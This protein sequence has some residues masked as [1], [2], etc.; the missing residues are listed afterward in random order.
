MQKQ[1]VILSVLVVFSLTAGLAFAA[2]DMS[3]DVPFAFYVGD[4]VYPAGQYHFDMNADKYATASFVNIWAAKSENDLVIMATAGTDK[5]A[6]SNQL[7]FNKY[8]E[9]HFLSSITINGYKAT[10][11]VLGL[12]KEAISQAKQA[13]G[14]IRV[15]QK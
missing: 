7:V 1:L 8:G 5:N 15:A 2:I 12:E 4:Q 3:V 9:K 14:V 11:K 13:P 10:L 6:S